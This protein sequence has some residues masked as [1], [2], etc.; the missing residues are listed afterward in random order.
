MRHDDEAKLSESEQEPRD[1]HDGGVAADAAPTTAKKNLVIGDRADASPILPARKSPT[2]PDVTEESAGKW[3]KFWQGVLHVDTSKM[4][5]GIGFR[6][7]LGV[8]LPL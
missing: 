7:A 4:D 1:L 2:P 3:L 5:L 6:N 8:A